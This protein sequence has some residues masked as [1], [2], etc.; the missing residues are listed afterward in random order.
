MPA[1]DVRELQR[2]KKALQAV[3][4]TSPATARPASDLP[5]EIR[6][7]LGRYID[8]GFIREGPSGTYYL[9]EDR[10]SA[11]R[12]SQIVKSVVFWF[13]VIILPVIILQ[14]SNSRPA[15]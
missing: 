13:L 5:D 1:I 15:P 3:G 14:I 9:D 12:R 8:A 11:V 4:A 7:E 6:A 2:A 10:A